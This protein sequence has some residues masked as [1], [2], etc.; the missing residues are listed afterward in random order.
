MSNVFDEDSLSALASAIDQATCTLIR[1]LPRI[2][3]E[4]SFTEQFL[5]EIRRVVNG[6][7]LDFKPR[8]GPRLA[9]QSQPDPLVLSAEQFDGRT[10]GDRGRNSEENDT[11]ADVLIFLDTAGVEGLSP[12]KGLLAQAKMQKSN[13]LYTADDELF[14]QCSK[15]YD[16]T[17]S[18]YAFI[19]ATN[20]IFV[21]D[22]PI[23]QDVQRLRRKDATWSV[24]DLIANF[25]DC[26]IGD[27][28][29]TEIDV[30]PF[31]DVAQNLRRRRFQEAA[32][33]E[34]L[35]SLVI[36]AGE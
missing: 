3:Q 6:Y 16:I 31:R 20:G 32:Q 5:G 30:G 23:A 28:G 13:F 35:Q 12:K 2:A 7:T 33:T 21:F 9:F 29:I 24:G 17:D 15:M 18:S 26:S 8:Q 10:L 36:S 34:E 19:Y 1:R 4:P 11:G 27:R 25:I 22:N 14:E